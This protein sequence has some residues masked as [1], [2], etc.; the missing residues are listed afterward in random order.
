MIICLYYYDVIMSLTRSLVFKLFRRDCNII[1]L[2]KPLFYIMKSTERH[3]DVLVWKTGVLICYYLWN[4]LEKLCIIEINVHIY[5]YTHT[6]TC[7]YMWIPKTRCFTSPEKKQICVFTPTCFAQTM[8]SWG[9]LFSGCPVSAHLYWVTST[10]DFGP[11]FFS[12]CHVFFAC[13]C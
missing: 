2:V 12:S 7:L 9:F 6:Q 1:W 5:I 8:P 11:V 4:P 3:S 10:T 13:S